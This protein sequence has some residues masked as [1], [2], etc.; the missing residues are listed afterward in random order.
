MEFKVVKGKTFS[1]IGGRVLIE[2]DWNLK[3]TV[4][5]DGNTLVVV[6]IESDW[7]LK[8]HGCQEG[9]LRQKQY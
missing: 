3:D 6:L 5:G 7:N 4:Q 2:S 8:R 1:V 9:R